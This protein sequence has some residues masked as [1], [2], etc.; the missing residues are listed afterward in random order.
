MHNYAGRGE[1]KKETSNQDLYE[2]VLFWGTRWVGGRAKENVWQ[3]QVLNKDHMC[4]QRSPAASVSLRAS[5]SRQEVAI[6][7]I[8]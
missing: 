2:S 6:G 1:M 4:Q 7:S 5:L 8:L 3:V